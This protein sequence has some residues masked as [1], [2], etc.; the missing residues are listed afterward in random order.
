MVSFLVLYIFLNEKTGLKLSL[1]I[2]K[3]INF[4]NIHIRYVVRNKN[5]NLI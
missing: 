1:L 5:F 3:I 4:P 2:Y